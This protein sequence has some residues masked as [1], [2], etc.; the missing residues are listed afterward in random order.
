[1]IEI[2]YKMISN[3]KSSRLTATAYKFV[4]LIVIGMLDG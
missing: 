2:Q 4:G 3:V 1:M